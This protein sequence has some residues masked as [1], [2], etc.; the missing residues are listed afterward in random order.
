[1]TSTTHDLG[2]LPRWN[3]SNVYPGLESDDFKRSASDLAAKLDDLDRYL[4]EKQIGEAAAESPSALGEAIEGYL[5]RMNAAL[6]LYATLRA[7][8]WSFVTTDLRRHS[9][10]SVLRLQMQ[11]VRLQ[12]QGTRFQGWTGCS[13]E[14]CRLCWSRAP[15]RKRTLFFSER[16]RSRAA[17]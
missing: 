13:A 14:P 9:E 4:A 12:Q 11:N 15:P 1:M 6:R 17:I 16:R 2:P 7:Y 3:L 10:A 8:V 5:E